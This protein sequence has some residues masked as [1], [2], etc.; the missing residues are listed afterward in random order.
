MKFNRKSN[1]KL[2]GT[3]LAGLMLILTFSCKNSS[4]NQNPLLVES[5]NLH[6]APPFDKITN[7]HYKPA[8]E[9]A[10]ELAREDIDNIVNNSEAPNFHNTIE[11]LEFAGET[12]SRVSS[13]FYNLNQSNTDDQMQQIAMDISP[14]LSDYNNDISLNQ[15]LFKRIKDVYENRSNLNLTKEQLRLTEETYK[16]FERN[17]ANLEGEKRDRYKEINKD[18]SQLSL[19]FGQNVLA[20]TNSFIV[21]ITDKDQLSGLPHFALMAAAAEAKERE[22][23]GWVFTLQGPSFGPILKYADNRD[24]REK[25][26]KGFNTR[27]IYDEYDNRDIVKKIAQLRLERANILGYKTH[28]EY[29]LEKNMAKTPETVNSFLEELLVKSMPYAKQEVADIQKYANKNGFK[30]ELMPWDFSYWS[31]KYKDEKYAIN[32]QLLKPY[33]KL[34]SVEQ[35]IFD[36]ASTLFD[37]KF[38]QSTNIP[39]Y[40]QDVKV[41]EVYEN[42]VYKAL[43]YIDYFPR[44][45][46]RG[47]AWMTSFREQHIK[48]GVEYRPFV[49]VVCNFTK[50]TEDT[51]SLLT[52][53]EFTTL[54]HEFGHALHGILAEGSYTSLTGTSVVRD[55]VELPSQI[56]ENWA[57]EREFLEK[58]ATHYQ[59]GEKIPAELITKIIEARNFLSGYSSVRQLTFGINDMAWHNLDSI[60]SI[61]DVIAFEKRAVSKTR[62]LKDIDSTCFSTSFSHIFAGGYSAGYY[63][64][65]W[66]EVLEADAFSLFK[67]KGIFNREVADS[68]RE[69]ILSKGNLEDADVIYRKFR[70]R[71]PKIESLLD[72]FG[73]K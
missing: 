4:M 49:S 47:G 52:F 31:E 21:H 18:L 32:D 41:F 35:A 42:D 30:G 40:H 45:S 33:L 43:L 5:T 23:E 22:L 11:S 17:G 7:E 34:E 26:W 66:A 51:P 20:S 16:S 53:G 62:L 13:I 14:M 50:P 37:L 64:Y 55:F 15:D 1:I 44:A 27:S 9:K 73:M 54:L 10:I 38:V 58:F 72:K 12:L 19:Q 28:A 24:L 70:G 36:L 67:E 65:K 69:N 46:K 6:N 56:M 57:T 48:N 2:L 68:F 8:F 71:D 3:I 29:V 59:T 63:S 39:V 61:D 60:D 25:I